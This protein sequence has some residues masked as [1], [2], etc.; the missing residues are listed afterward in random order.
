MLQIP[1]TL[2]VCDLINAGVLRAP[3]KERLALRSPPPPP[4]KT[5][6]KI[7]EELE[8]EA[9]SAK[10]FNAFYSWYTAMTPVHHFV[11]DTLREIAMHEPSPLPTPP[12]WI[13]VDTRDKVTSRIRDCLVMGTLTVSR[14]M[15]PFS[16]EQSI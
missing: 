6:G 3:G 15:Y 7:L 9:E 5:P 12:P 4:P 2:R 13:R 16:S 1:A 14:F 10:L 8:T 11:A